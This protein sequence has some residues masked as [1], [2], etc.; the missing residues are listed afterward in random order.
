MSEK[1]KKI[2]ILTA[3]AGFGHR[4]AANAVAEAFQDLYQQQVE[5]IIENPLDDKRTPFFLRDSQVDYDKWIKSVPELYRFGYEAS[6]SRL[7]TSIIEN[8]LTVLL[9]E[10]IRDIIKKYQPDAII[11]TYLLYQPAISAVL[12]IWNLNIPFSTV[13]T[14]LATVHRLWFFKDVDMCFAPTEEVYALAVEYGMDVEKIKITGIPVSPKITKKEKSKAEIRKQLD[15][16]PELTTILVVGSSRVKN[17]ENVLAVINHFGKKVQLIVVA[18]KDK[19]LYKKLLAVDWH[20]PTKRIEYSS[21]MPML[22]QASDFIVSKA[23]G[24]IVTESLAAGLPMMLVDV[25]PGQEEGNADYVVKNNAGERVETTLEMLKTLYHWT[26]DDNRM[27]GVLSE[28]CHLIGKENAAFDVAQIVF[29]ETERGAMW[30][31]N[32]R[33]KRRLSLIDLLSRFQIDWQD[34]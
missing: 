30:Q 18:G 26:A 12:T 17:I 15:L 21:E 27:L 7:P 9:F 13:V 23:G 14:D 24:L 6:D 4:S 25:L 22:M 2:L 8:A 20:I 28:N 3:D 32:T 33:S 11:T 29:Q 31:F 1:I 19:V 10:V 16:D 5:V 34:R